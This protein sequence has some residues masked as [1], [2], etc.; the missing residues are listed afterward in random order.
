VMTGEPAQR[1]RRE[2]VHVDSPRR[3]GSRGVGTPTLRA[4]CHTSE[5]FLT[6]VSAGNTPMSW[7]QPAAAS[8]AVSGST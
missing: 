6:G 3:D 4:G 8:K 5:C 2:R 7:T 1:G